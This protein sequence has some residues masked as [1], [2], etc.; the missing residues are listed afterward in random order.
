MEV[1]SVSALPYDCS[2]NGL[3]HLEGDTVVSLLLTLM[4]RE[5]TFLPWRISTF[6]V[7][8]SG[9]LCE[10]KTRTFSAVEVFSVFYLC[11]CVSL[12]LSLYLSLCLSLSL[13]LSVCVCLSVSCFV[14]V[15]AVVVVVVCSDVV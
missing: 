3:L 12:S 4:R 1:I 2:D 10:N 13:S 5:M 11:V 8:L 14:V 15:V 6:S 7:F 9:L